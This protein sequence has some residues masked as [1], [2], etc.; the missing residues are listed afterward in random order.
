MAIVDAASSDP[1][2]DVK[3]QYFGT[4]VD[5]R[6]FE[7]WLA[8]IAHVRDSG[9]RRWLSGHHNLHS[10]YLLHRLHDVRRFYERCD[11]CYI[12]GMPVRLLLNVFGVGTTAAQRFSLM[13]HFLAL[14]QH[15]EHLDW[16]VFYVGSAESV[17]DEG[18]ALIAKRFPRLRIQ[19]HHGYNPNAADLVRAINVWRPDVL[20]VGMGMPLQEQWLLEHIDTLDVGFATQ[21]G[22][23]LDYYTGAQA[24]PP[25]WMSRTGFAWAYRLAHDPARLWRRYLVEPW[26]LLPI[27]LH[28][29][30][31]VR[32]LRRAPG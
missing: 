18:R 1:V 3:R 28:H 26:R 32:R 19:M 31:R 16:S 6:S 25:L 13:D 7:Q 29:W 11:D 8:D 15:A 27:T 23:T 21:A 17:V 2:Q 12:D 20:L 4:R 5:P 30:R 22:A 24:R 10:L 14:L 9:R